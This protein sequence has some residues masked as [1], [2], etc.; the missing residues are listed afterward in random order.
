MAKYTIVTATGP[1]GT[2]IKDGFNITLRDIVDFVNTCNLV[3]HDHHYRI[4][5]GYPI[6]CPDCHIIVGVDE[7]MEGL[8]RHCQPCEQKHIA[9]NIN[10]SKLLKAYDVLGI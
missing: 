2:R 1:E 3:N 6:T 7:E 4:D 5:L 10:R 9:A 8:E